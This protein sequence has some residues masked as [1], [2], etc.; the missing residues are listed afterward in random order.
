M[1]YCNH[2]GAEVLEPNAPFCARCGCQLRNDTTEQMSPE[3]GAHEY[4]QTAAQG[5]LNILSPQR[6]LFMTIVSY[7][8]YLFYWFYITWKQYRDT[9][10]ER[11]YPV[12][13]A[14]TLFVPI[15]GLF[16]TH[17]H[18]RTYRDMMRGR[19]LATTISAGW[20]VTAI[21]ISFAI[22]WSLVWLVFNAEITQQLA[23]ALAIRDGAY[24]AIVAW[25]LLHVQENLNKYWQGVSAESV[26]NARTSVGEVIFGGLGVLSWIGTLKNLL[27]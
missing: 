16:R 5:L 22:S 13:H 10:R 14:L 24:I 2:C 23:V 9:T 15:Y 8:L 19:G 1:E 25:L 4:E 7:G 3:S 12:W 26:A 11:A 17:A 20:A 21:L 18:M 6:I 27:G